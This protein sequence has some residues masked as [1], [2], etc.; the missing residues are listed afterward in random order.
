MIKHLLLTFLLLTGS[1]TLGLAQ[2]IDLGRAT[3]FSALANKKIVFRGPGETKIQGNIGIS[4]GR[5]IEGEQFLDLLGRKERNSELAIAGMQNANRVYN[6]I[7]GRTI[8]QDHGPVLGNNNSLGPGTYKISSDATLNSTLRLDGQ[9]DINSKF[10]FIIEGDFISNSGSI[11]FSDMGASAKN[12]YWIVKGNAT[13]GAGSSFQGNIIA[14][15]DIT[16]YNR[17]AL[18]GRAFSLDGT[19]YFDENSTAMPIVVETNLEVEK[20]VEYKD[21]TLGAK[22]I[23]TI[24]ATNKGLGEAMHVVVKEQIPSG[25]KFIRFISATKGTYDTE[26]HQWLVG[27]MTVGPTETLKL[28]FEIVG[29]GNIKNEVVIIGDNPDPDPDNDED[30]EVIILPDLGV[31]KELLNPKDSYTVGDFVEYKITLRNYAD[32]AESNVY[33]REKLPQGLEFVSYTASTGVYNQATGVFYV[34]SVAGNSNVTLTIRGRLTKVGEVRN[35]VSIIAKDVEPT[36]PNNPTDPT[37]PTDPNN[38]DNPGGDYNDSDPDNDEDDVTIPEVKCKTELQVAFAAAPT[39]VCASVTGITLKATSDVVGGTYAW[40]LPTGWRFAEGTNPNSSEITVNVG[41]TSGEQTVKVTVRDQCGKTASAETKV[42]VTGA[43]VVPAITGAGV[44]CFNG[45]IALSAGESA[46]ELTYEW[47]V[48]AN[49]EI[50]GDA[51]G[52]SV[53]VRPKGGS[54]LGGKVTL[55]ATNSCGFSSTSVKVL[56]VSP[57]PV[58]PIAINGDVNVCAN[59]PVTFST[60]VVAGATSYTWTLPAGWQF[61]PGTATDAR[62]VTVIVGGASGEK[63]ISVKANNACSSSEPF[64]R[65]IKVNEAPNVDNFTLNGDAEACQNATLVFT[66]TALQG[67]S[68]EFSVSGGLTKVS[69]TG[70]K[71]TVKAGAT[72]G[73]VSVT[74]TDFCGNK[75]TVSKD[76]VV[77]PMLATPT[78]SGTSS[79]CQSSTGNVYTASVYEG[80]VTYKWTANGGLTIT[81]GSETATVEV[82]VGANEG[83]LTLEVTNGC[84][85]AKTTKRIGINP[86]PQAPASIAGDATVC[87][88]SPQT[89]T[90]AAV[91]GATSYTWTLPAGWQFAPGTATDAREVTVTVGSNGGRISAKANNACGISEAAASLEVA[92]N[93]VLPAPAISGSNGACAG[94]ELTYTI[95]EVNGATGYEWNVPRTWKLKTGQNTTSVTVVVGEE[96]GDMTVAVRNECGLGGEATKAVAPVLAPAAP[97]ISGN[98]DVCEYTGQLTYTVSNPEEGATYTWSLPQGWTFEGPNTGT[99][100]TVNAGATAGAITVVAENSCDSSEGQLEVAIFTPPVTPGQITDNSNVC[101]GLV[102]SIEPVAGASG[103]TWTVSSGFTIASGQGTTTITV[104]ADRADAQ[105]TVTVVANNGPC[106]SMEASAPVDAA[107]ADGNLD[108]PKAFSPNGDGKND[109]WHIKNLE[110]FPNNEIVILNR[111]GSEVYKTKGYQNNWNGQ[112]LGQGTYFYKVRVTVCDGVVKEFTGYTTIFR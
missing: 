27:D 108:F 45:S 95:P 18:I 106:S 50:V 15:K 60:P 81:S 52:A 101:D 23:Y 76:V 77:T 44:V 83:T 107:K 32:K 98:S 24:K 34:P 51:N 63:E 70:N 74:V 13:I 86:L 42:N 72:N 12:V 49:L 17:A 14:T 100:V 4:P 61:A 40:V 39:T 99:S 6:E 104:K 33:V 30:D 56:T 105:G 75:L 57:A 35:V 79:A 65:T 10:I 16:F 97:A 93:D 88:G 73:T 59:K 62:E 54:L 48:D 43:P 90:A 41:A 71:V 37:N 68:Y 8:T 87:A 7:L 69:Q 36:D 2:E 20:D 103:Y 19:I 89:Y 109:N 29:T 58:A 55:K 25:L 78:I 9:G 5:T 110:K 26:S 80:A 82:S 102:F 111:W 94:T 96:A 1:I 22:V 92:V 46:E 112:G 11:Q 47:T 67:A 28:E 84:F 3:T 21:I 66:A 64:T 91:A 53:E 31:T 38:P 85:T